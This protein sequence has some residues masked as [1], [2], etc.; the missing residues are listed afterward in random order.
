M[1]KHQKLSLYGDDITCELKEEEEEKNVSRLSPAANIISQ[2]LLSFL[3][4]MHAPRSAIFVYKTLYC[5]INDNR[6]VYKSIND[7]CGN[8]KSHGINVEFNHC[9]K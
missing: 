6:F 1:P 5:A 2:H 8:A 3:I 4:N 7:F 9:I